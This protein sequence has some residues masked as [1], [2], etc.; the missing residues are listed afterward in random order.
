M[1]I[2][3][4]DPEVTSSGEIIGVNIRRNSTYIGNIEKHYK[5]RFWDN[6]EDREKAKTLA[7]PKIDD[8][9]IEEIVNSVFRKPVLNVDNFEV[10]LEN[11]KILQ[12]YIKKSGNQKGK[13]CYLS[14]HKWAETHF[15]LTTTNIESNKINFID[16]KYFSNL[17]EALKKNPVNFDNFFKLKFDKTTEYAYIPT[18][19][20]NGDQQN[21]EEILQILEN[22]NNPLPISAYAQTQGDKTIVKANVS[23]KGFLIENLIREKYVQKFDQYPTNDI[24]D[25]F[26]DTISV[27]EKDDKII[28]STSADVVDWISD[29]EDLKWF[30]NDD[31]K[32]WSFSF[33]RDYLP[34]PP[35]SHITIVNS[36][37]D[38][39][40]H[41]TKYD[42]SWNI[43]LRKFLNISDSIKFFK[44][45]SKGENNID[46]N[47]LDNR[48]TKLLCSKQDNPIPC[49][50]ASDIRN[51]DNI[52][53]IQEFF[54]SD[55]KVQVVKKLSTELSK[56]YSPVLSDMR[57]LLAALYMLIL[58]PRIHRS[59]KRPRPYSAPHS[60]N[61]SRRYHSYPNQDWSSRFP[62]PPGSHP[63]P[64]HLR[65]HLGG[66]D[67]KT[68]SRRVAIAVG[69]LLTFA[70]AFF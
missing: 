47:T 53:L 43:I 56:Y 66:A 58:P 8:N 2:K 42:S 7:T 31:K 37:D 26:K 16:L 38:Q 36:A 30:L 68:A 40:I 63:Y 61:S 34:P 6:S 25:L 3:G 44:D 45:F 15:A 64:P 29:V 52:T 60:G 70:A 20:Q 54:Y 14:V 21:Q 57:L 55:V 50:N 22:L 51:K 9:E 62:L 48:L 24:F 17:Y 41:W 10:I 59:N 32:E 69:A 33:K 18:K 28:L 35:P 39:N 12:G 4:I 27:T 1:S 49:R 23:K 19:G 11:P 5:I 46:L 13:E 65:N 67:R